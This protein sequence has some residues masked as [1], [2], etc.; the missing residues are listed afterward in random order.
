M[1]KPVVLTL[2]CTLFGLK[3]GE[4]E[5]LKCAAQASE[6]QQVYLS[7]ILDFKLLIQRN[8][9]LH[10]QNAVRGT[11]W[12]IMDLINFWCYLHNK[13]PNII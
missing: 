8:Y 3:D 11:Y 5:Q 10:L 9:K 2:N 13:L 7:R 12:S 1:R 4:K 6:P